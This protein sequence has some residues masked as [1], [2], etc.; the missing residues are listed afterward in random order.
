VPAHSAPGE[1]DSPVA[2]GQELSSDAVP[3]DVLSSLV[4]TRS[5]GERRY[6]AYSP[7][8]TAEEVEDYWLSVDLEAVVSRE[9]WR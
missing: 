2:V 5:D 4:R 1:T 9:L 6:V 8:A 3:E 7:V